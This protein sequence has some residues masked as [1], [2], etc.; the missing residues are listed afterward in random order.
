MNEETTYVP[1]VCNIN[2][3]E[4][5]RRRNIGIAGLA[6]LILLFV[7]MIGFKVPSPFRILLFVP[8][9]L[10]TTGFLQAKNRFCVGYASASMHHTGE[11][12][13]EIEEK[14]AIAADKAHARK[15]NLQVAG[16]AFVITVVL[17]IVPIG[18]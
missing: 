1:G 4:V 10:M 11:R 17:T 6:L 9:F 2:K 12:L 14:M 8:A 13:E 16:I 5:R 18:Y 7:G 3:V 15:M